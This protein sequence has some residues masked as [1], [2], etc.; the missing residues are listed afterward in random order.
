[1]LRPAEQPLDALHDLAVLDL[2]G[3]VYVGRSAVPGAPDALARARQ[4]GMHLAFVTNNAA[5][6]PAEVADQLVTLGIAAE[7]GDVVTSA[8]AT[9]RVIAATVPAGSEVFVIGG[10][11]LEV[12]LRERGLVPVVRASD[13]VAAVAQGYGP[14]M[15]WRQVVVGAIVVRTG[16]PW[17]A[18]NTDMTIPT[19]EGLGPGNGTLVRLVAEF[20]GREPLVAG[21]PERPLFE[22]TR[23]RVG[24]ARPLVVGDRLDTDIA[25]AARLDWPSLLVMTGVT[26]LAELVAAARGER[27]AYLGSDLAALHDPHPVPE[28]ADGGWSLHGW[29]GTVESGSLRVTGDGTVDDWWRVVAQTSWEHLD[30]TG[31]PVDVGGVVAPG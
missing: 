25:G 28:R 7:A 8:Q 30:A 17:V 18:A 24:G 27:P 21:K 10:E 20:A 3:V 12:A 9:A 26:G 22:E 31:G 29:H 13:A 14:S 15:P 6:T 4:Q 1:V 16:V 2:D 19:D 5:R 23:D 11:G